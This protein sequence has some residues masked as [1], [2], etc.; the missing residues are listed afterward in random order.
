MVS[1][2]RLMLFVTVFNDFAS[3]ASE[4]SVLAIADT[5]PRASG[6][7]YGGMIAFKNW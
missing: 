2:R 7:L 4:M 6:A 5:Q 3:T 1:I